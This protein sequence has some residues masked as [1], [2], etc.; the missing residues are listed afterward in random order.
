MIKAL[1]SGLSL[2]L[3]RLFSLLPF[4]LLDA[5]GYI[6]TFLLNNIFPYRKEIILKNLR[7]AFPEKSEKELLEIKKKYY[8]YFSRLFVENIKMFNLSLN[9]LDKRISLE[10][11]E[12]IKEYFD[13]GS[14]IALMAAHYGNWEW[15]LGLRKD[16]PH[17]S[18]GIYKSLNNRYYNRFF[19]RQRAKFGTEMVNMREVPR[20]LLKHRGNKLSTLTVFISDQSPVWEEIQYWTEFLNQNTPVYLGPEKLATKFKMAVVYFRVRVKTKHSYSVQAIP[21]CDDASEID[22][23]R[24]T[25]QYLQLLEE[26]IRNEP[27]YWLW[28]HRRWKLTE[29]REREEKL[30][31]R[32]FEGKWKRKSNA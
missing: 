3:L 30:G 32:R 23:Y 21:I 26:D 31:I 25:E 2:I 15:L 20:I 1:A 18:I 8:S 11:P 14:D 28:S 27:E 19:V 5:I 4:F 29:K 10:N 22:Q 6:M 7:H 12:L 13:N 17:H 9:Q 16:I 24:I